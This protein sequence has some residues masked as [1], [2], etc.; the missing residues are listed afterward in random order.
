MA[1]DGS[2]VPNGMVQLRYF[3]LGRHKRVGRDSA[4][5]LV[6]DDVMGLIRDICSGVNDVERNVLCFLS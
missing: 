4:V 6:V 5:Q 3:A 1:K 2:Y